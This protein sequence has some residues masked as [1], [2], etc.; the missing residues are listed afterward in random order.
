MSRDLA[1][2][3]KKGLEELAAGREQMTP[4]TLMPAEDVG[5]IQ[6]SAACAMLHS[7]Y[8]E[9]EEILKLIALEW[10]GQMPSRMPG[11]TPTKS[12]VSL[13]GR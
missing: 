8:T 1:T 4:L 11:T 10:D 5:V 2:K 12:D 6:R 13:D 3:I 7:F 9:I